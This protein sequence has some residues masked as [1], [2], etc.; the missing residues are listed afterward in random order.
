[1]KHTLNTDRKDAIVKSLTTLGYSPTTAKVITYFI[2]LKK[3]TARDIEHTMNLRQP[4]VSVTT[5][6]LLEKNCIKATP[7]KKPHKGRPYYIY[8]ESNILDHITR[9]SKQRIKELKDAIHTITKH[10]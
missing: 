9:E 2:I 6:Q 3:G 8:E 5:R 4:E 7:I 1:M 10:A